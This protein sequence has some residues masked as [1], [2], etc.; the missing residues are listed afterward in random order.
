MHTY[1]YKSFVQIPPFP[2]SPYPPDDHL[3][4]RYTGRLVGVLRCCCDWNDEFR[5][6]GFFLTLYGPCALVIKEIKQRGA[7]ATCT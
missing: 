5:V 1:A 7:S 2:I 6:L 3:S 4:Y